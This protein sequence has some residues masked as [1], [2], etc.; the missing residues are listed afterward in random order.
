MAI[1]TTQIKFLRQ[2]LNKI[3]KGVDKLTQPSREIA[4]SKTALQ[5]SIMFLGLT[6]GDI[7]EEKTPYPESDNKDSQ[8]I[9]AR[10]DTSDSDYFFDAADH[11][12]QVK[13]LRADLSAKIDQLKSL[14]LEA[15]GTNVAQEN[16]PFFPTHIITALTSLERSKLWLGMELNRI[17]G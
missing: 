16:Q 6:L 12:G 1:T 8:V 13:E 11:I 5:E 3:E 4:L 7:N 14:Y 15:P 2:S 17:K 9:E 10:A